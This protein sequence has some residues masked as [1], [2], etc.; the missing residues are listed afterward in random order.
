MC[1]PVSTSCAVK[2]THFF[3]AIEWV[4]VLCIAWIVLNIAY[5][6][7]FLNKG[8]GI[9]NWLIKE[10]DLDGTITASDKAIKR[11]RRDMWILLGLTSLVIVLI[12][13]L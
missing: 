10:Q 5:P 4:F 1:C 3:K 13:L 11:F 9:I 7:R 6:K 2:I 8:L 12:E